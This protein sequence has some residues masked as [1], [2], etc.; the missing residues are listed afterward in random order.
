MKW[1]ILS[2]GI[3]SGFVL[4]HVLALWMERKGWIYYKHTKP[5]RSALGNAFL[6][7]QSILEPNKKYIIELKKEDKKQN[8]EVGDE[9]DDVENKK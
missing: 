5:S 9:P 1:I 8:E 3:V 6:E 7:V 2:A 4:L